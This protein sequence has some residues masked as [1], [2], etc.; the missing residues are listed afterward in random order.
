[1]AL[2]VQVLL[3]PLLVQRLHMQ[4]AVHL[5]PLVRPQMAQQVRQTLAMVQAVLLL[6]VRRVA[7]VPLAAVAL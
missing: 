6:M 4:Q 7:L 2:V 3:I 1:V 5:W